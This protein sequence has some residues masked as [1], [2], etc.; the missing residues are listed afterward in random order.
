MN[1]NQL[2]ED[3]FYTWSLQQAQLLREK[4]FDRVDWENVIEEI[5][6]LGR[7]EYRAFVS[8][9]E[10]L[11][12]HLLKWQYQRDYRSPSWRHSIDKQRIAIERIIED[13]PGLQSRLD[14]A[15]SKG[16]K[17]GRKGAIK[18]TFMDAKIFPE[19]CPYTWEELTDD[20]FFPDSN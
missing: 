5:E 9:I 6:A 10:Q 15:I 20:N 4:Q 17:Y 19:V 16:Y 18:E 1:D 2:Y 13:N 12:L 11:T 14:E 7:S 8:A 3:D